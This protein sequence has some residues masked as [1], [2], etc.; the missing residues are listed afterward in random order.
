MKEEKQIMIIMRGIPGSGK[1]TAANELKQVLLAVGAREV[2]IFSTD[3]F[4]YRE[5]SGIY[6]WDAKKIGVAHNWNQTRVKNAIAA[7]MH[8]IVDNT[9]LDGFALMPYFD[10]AARY[11]LDVIMHT[12]DTPVETCIER[13]KDR[14]EDRR[15]PENVIRDMHDK[16]I[17][18]KDKTVESELAKAKI[19]SQI[20]SQLN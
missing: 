17:R 4:W 19:R 10:M 20:R 11:D 12:V 8:V 6:D 5:K 3:D 9:N 16:L 14:P 1:S 2:G 7:G 15:V 13:Q 18:N